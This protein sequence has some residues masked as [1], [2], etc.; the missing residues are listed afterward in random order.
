MTLQTSDAVA[1]AMLDALETTVGTGMVWIFRTGTVP[2]N[3]AAADT[4]T[5][6]GTIQCP[7]DWLAAASSRAKALAGTWA[8]TAL[9]AGSIGHFRAYKADGTTVC[10]QGTPA[11]TGGT[12]DILL[13][14]LNFESVG[15]AFSITAFTLTDGNS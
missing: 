10:F 4:G 8:G 13:S 9:V 11:L 1:N 6:L 12:A 14:A 2:A 15:Q 7:S 3:C 5:V